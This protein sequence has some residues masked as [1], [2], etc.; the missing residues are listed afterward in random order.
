MRFNT[1]K[2]NRKHSQSIDATEKSVPLAAAAENKLNA[3]AIHNA[4]AHTAT[5]EA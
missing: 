2:Q 1:Q 5:V 3:A 4:T